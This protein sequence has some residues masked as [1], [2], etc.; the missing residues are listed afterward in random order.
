VTEAGT[1][2]LSAFNSCFSD[3]VSANVIFADFPENILGDDRIGCA[4]DSLL[5]TGLVPGGDYIWSTG[6]SGS[7]IFVTESGTYSVT[8]NFFGCLRSDEV[9]V[10]LVDFVPV[11]EII[12]PN[13]FT[14]NGDARNTTFRPFLPSA[15]EQDLCELSVLDVDLSVYNRWGGLLNEEGDCE[16]RGMFNNNDLPEGTYYFIV[17]L[18]SVCRDQG[19]ERRI[20]GHFTLLR[21]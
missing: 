14:P 4:G 6:Q 2:T 9:E 16:W 3:S 10:D 21:D 18:K 1:Y 15:P 7:S 17:N 19:G 11:D 13:I 12:M 20:D 8:L 5:L